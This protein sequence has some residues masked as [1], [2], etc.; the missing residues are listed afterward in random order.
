MSKE[1]SVKVPIEEWKAWKTL[2]NDKDNWG[3]KAAFQRETKRTANTLNWVLAKGQCYPSTIKV[4]R[5]FVK[6]YQKQIP[7]ENA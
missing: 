2:F 5:Q 4:I 7:V 6:K 1:I 3:I